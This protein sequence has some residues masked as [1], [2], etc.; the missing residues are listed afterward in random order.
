MLMRLSLLLSLVFIVPLN[1]AFAEPVINASMSQY[2]TYVNEVMQKS[3]V[4]G[5]AVAIV[6]DGRVIYAR[7][8]GMRDREAGLPVTENTLFA[9][10]STTKAMTATAAAMLVDEGK[11]NLRKPII[12]YVPDFRLK[13]Q[14][15]TLQTN[16]I[17]LMSHR[18]GVPRHDVAWYGYD[19]FGRSYFW[20]RLKYLEPSAGFRE[21]WQYNNFMFMA[22]GYVIEKVSGK[23]WEEFVRTR[24]FG[25][26]G[27]ASTNF[28]VE[29][30]EA[31]ADFSRPYTFRAGS[32]VR[33]P[34]RPIIGMAPAGAVNSSISDMAKWLQ[35]N[36]DN[37]ALNGTV[38]VQPATMATVHQPHMI[39]SRG[40]TFPE[41]S[42]SGYALGWERQ[43]YRGKDL[44]WHT[45]GIDGF[46]TFVGFM[47]SEKIGIVVFQNTDHKMVM[48]PL[49]L[50][51]FDEVLQLTAIDWYERF[52]PAQPVPQ[53]KIYERGP[54]PRPP[55][56]YTG[57]FNHPGYGVVVISENNGGLSMSF[58]NM[59]FG[60]EH[61]NNGIFKMSSVDI[62]EVAD[63][64][65]VFFRVDGE[66]KISELLMKLE[67]AVAP[68]VFT[69]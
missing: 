44:I 36:I 18:T 24:I 23:T 49:G 68:I 52:N 57:T 62:P 4:P 69:K 31:S 22:A 45:G 34:M 37:G 67:P 65:P 28:T 26:L 58:H 1:S 13:D 6:K 15:A 16:M 21:T 29:E 50:K 46:L 47:P 33:V 35:F 42:H 38:L 25:P 10:G 7:G 54:L 63:M 20:E 64:D 5:T 9:I 39:M 19:G 27:M 60:L 51:A 48:V 17:D 30:T 12:E 14:T 32:I 2:E 53:Q 56:D 11:L 8:F 41:F 66:G 43:N 61:L 55:A 3:S 59:T 40:P